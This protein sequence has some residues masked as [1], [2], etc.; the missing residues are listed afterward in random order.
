M[1]PHDP[2]TLGNYKVKVVNSKSNDVRTTLL[3]LQL[4]AMRVLKLKAT[5]ATDKQFMSY[6]SFFFS[7]NLMAYDEIGCGFVITNWRKLNIDTMCNII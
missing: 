4:P 5:A 3:H 1:W 7:G 6:R 2:K